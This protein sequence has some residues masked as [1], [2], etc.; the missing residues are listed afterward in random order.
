MTLCHLHLQIADYVPQYSIAVSGSKADDA[1]TNAVIN[2]QV[3]N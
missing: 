2:Q 3:A 1:R